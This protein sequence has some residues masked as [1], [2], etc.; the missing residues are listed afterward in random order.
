[1]PLREALILFGCLVVAVILHELSHGVVALWLGDDTAK[2]AG[3]LTLNPIPHIDPFGSIIL[4]AIGALAGLPIFGY[5][6]PVPV[7]PGRLRHP[8]RDIIIVSLAG[9]TTNLLLMAAAALVARALYRG[10][11]V[12]P[13][14]IS[15]STSDVLIEIAFYFALVN[16]LLGLFNLLPIPP[17]DGSALLERMLPA[18]WLPA[19]YRFR[20]YGLLILFVLIFF[21]GVLGTIINPFFDALRHFV[22]G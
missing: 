12:L 20:P 13:G 14:T 4:P 19:W 15:Q 10:G 6:K 18:S 9:P 22:V 5:A 16:L 8:R 17:L 1:M 21:T 7:D 3:R 2:R 11:G